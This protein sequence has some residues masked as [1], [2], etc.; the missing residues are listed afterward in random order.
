M[1]HASVILLKT[2]DGGSIPCLA[3]ALDRPERRPSF[4]R[5][6][7]I[8]FGRQSTGFMSRKMYKNT[9]LDCNNINTCTTILHDPAADIV[10]VFVLPTR[11]ARVLSV[12]VTPRTRR[13]H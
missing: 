2:E 9:K 8:E 1:V 7:E 4:E 13:L 12:P 3:V 5:W 10:T 6:Y 11:Y